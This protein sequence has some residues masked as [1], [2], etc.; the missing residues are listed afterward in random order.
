MNKNFEQLIAEH[1]EGKSTLVEFV[2]RQEALS[3]AYNTYLSDNNL[4]EEEASASIFLNDFESNLMNNQHI[5][6]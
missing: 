5:I 6:L 4:K 1:Q 2:R 3:E